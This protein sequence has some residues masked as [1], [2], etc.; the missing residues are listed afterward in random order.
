MSITMNDTK[1]KMKLT[2]N[3]NRYDDQEHKKPNV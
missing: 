2:T 3:E 1:A